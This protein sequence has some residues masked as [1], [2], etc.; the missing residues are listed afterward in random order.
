VVVF[1]KVSYASYNHCADAHYFALIAFII[2]LACCP[3]CL[4]RYVLLQPLFL[5]D[6]TYMMNIDGRTVKSVAAA[7]KLGKPIKCGA[8]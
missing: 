5:L 1:D 2:A 6:P 3:A 7:A 8:K 4:S